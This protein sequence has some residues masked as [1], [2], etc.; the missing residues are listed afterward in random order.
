MVELDEEY[1]VKYLDEKLNYHPQKFNTN[2]FGLESFRYLRTKICAIIT[3]DLRN[4][5]SYPAF[6]IE[7][8]RY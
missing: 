1:S 5:K 7:E 6:K 4:T 3:H 2:P 8:T